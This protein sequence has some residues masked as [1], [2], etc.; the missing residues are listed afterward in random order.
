VGRMVLVG[1]LVARDLRHRPVQ[2]VLLLVV[3][4]AAM[5]TFTLRRLA[6]LRCRREQHRPPVGCA[7]SARRRHRASVWHVC[8]ARAVAVTATRGGERACAASASLVLAV[9]TTSSTG[10][11][12]SGRQSRISRAAQPGRDGAI[13]DTERGRRVGMAE[14]AERDKQQHLP[15]AAGQ[16]RESDKERGT[17]PSAAT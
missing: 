14:T 11:A 10:G 4:A 15:L 2:A 7:T 8:H 16:I 5:A 17:Q 1:R 12:C 13:A 9:A 3:I 6:D